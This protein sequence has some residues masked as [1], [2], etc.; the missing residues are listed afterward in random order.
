M[1]ITEI[2]F[3]GYP[4]TDMGRAR[5]FYEGVLGL[6]VA[7]TWGDKASPQWVE[8]NIGSGCLALITG[9]GDAWP[10]ANAGPAVALEVEDFDGAIEELKKAG[11]KFFWDAK[12]SPACHMAVVLDPDENRLVI[13]RRKHS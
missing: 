9:A 8:Y 2:A 13:H 3:T 7:S 5:M 6:V 1:K 11:V 4:V 12:E 10:P